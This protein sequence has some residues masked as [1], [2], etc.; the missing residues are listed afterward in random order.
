MNK[1]GKGREYLGLVHFL[2]SR[3]SETADKKTAKNECRPPVLLISLVLVH[4]CC[5]YLPKCFHLSVLLSCSDTKF[6]DPTNTLS[7][8]GTYEL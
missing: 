7:F 2:G 4:Q 1:R 3:I 8:L 5:V 6:A